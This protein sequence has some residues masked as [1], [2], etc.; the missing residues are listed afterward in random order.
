MQHLKKIVFVD[1]ISVALQ[2]NPE[3]IFSCVGTPSLPSGDA[4]LSAVFN[5][6]SS[7]GQ[8]INDYCL[9]VN[10]STV[11]VGT[12]KKVKNIISQELK[13]RN[14]SCAFDVASNPEFLKEG[15]ALNDFL[16]PDRVVVGV[17]STKAKE[18]L[19]K[20][21]KSFISKKN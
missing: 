18:I 19:E 14:S 1:S 12:A 15:D 5:V 16:M 2:Q 7:V 20:L 9:F 10:K 21:Y 6:A 11:P 4:D 17:Y 13:K 3:I 8:N